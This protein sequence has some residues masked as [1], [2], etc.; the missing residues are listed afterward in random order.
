MQIQSFRNGGYVVH[1]YRMEGS[2]CRFS[3]WYDSCLFVLD[4]ERIDARGRSYPVTP[5][6]MNYI[7]ANRPA[8]FASLALLP[9]AVA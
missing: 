6:Q 8:A 7:Q 3:I 4:A 2:R 9:R 5:R 1:R